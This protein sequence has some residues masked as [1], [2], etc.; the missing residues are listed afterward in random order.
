MRPR[1][2]PYGAP[3]DPR[4]LA[5][6]DKQVATLDA[7]LAIG[8]NPVRPVSIPCGDMALPA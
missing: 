2:R 1:K 3:V 5:A 4:L 6:F 8:P 7:G